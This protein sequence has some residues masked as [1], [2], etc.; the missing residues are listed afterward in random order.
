MR[1]MLFV[2]ICLWITCSIA[3]AE[4]PCVCGR[5][6]CI[7]FIQ[8]GDEGRAVNAIKKALFAQGFLA[9]K[10]PVNL[11]NAAT[12]EAV[13]AF[14]AANDLPITGRMDDETLTLLLWGVLPEKLKPAQP[15]S[16]SEVAWIPTDGGIRHH[17]DWACWKMYDPRLVSKRNAIKMNMLNCGTC[18]PEAVDTVLERD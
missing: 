3:C 1:K 11:F 18:H 10:A 8:E 16:A 17:C 4:I 2:L 5:T 7:C 15:W 14:Q 12:T 6:N 13:M 9:K